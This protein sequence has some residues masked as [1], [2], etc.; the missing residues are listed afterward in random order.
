[1]LIFL[2]HSFS[3]DLVVADY[4]F[5]RASYLENCVNKSRPMMH[6]NGRCQLAKKLRQQEKSEK[7]N[8]ERRDDT[9]KYGPLS[10]KS[11]FGSFAG[12]YAVQLADRYPESSSAKVIQM[13]RDF[14][15]PPDKSSL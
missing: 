7:Q 9:G 2:A 6:C 1:M 3:R 10:S 5:N 8:P 13:P 12:R 4:Y 15:H 11:F 14:F